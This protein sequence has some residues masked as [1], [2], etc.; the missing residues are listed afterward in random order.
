MVF[1]RPECGL[2]DAIGGSIIYGDGIAHYINDLH[3]LATTLT[4]GGNDAILDGTKL[5]PLPALAYYGGYLHQWSTT[6]QS[7]LAFSRVQLDGMPGQVANAYHFG[8]YAVINLIYHEPVNLTT[9]ASVSVRTFTLASNI[10]M[11]LRRS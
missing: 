8:D 2:N 11:G 6:Y 9:P 3:V 7:S 4:T 1:Q 5:E 10:C